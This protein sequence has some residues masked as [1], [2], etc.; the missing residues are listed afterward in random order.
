MLLGISHLPVAPKEGKIP[1]VHVH[2]NG[3]V[4]GIVK[5]AISVNKIELTGAALEGALAQRLRE[6]LA[7]VTWLKGWQVEIDPTEYRTGPDIKATL[8]LP[9]GGKAELWVVCKS[10]PRPHQI[11]F[12][13]T[14]DL[15]S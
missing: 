14:Q 7:G 1:L 4:H 11:S 13:R 12:D 2:E 10:N 8:P 6:L 5:T 3:Y 9:N 15:P